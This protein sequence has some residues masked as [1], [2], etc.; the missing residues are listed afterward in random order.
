[1]MRSTTL[2]AAALFLAL[3]LGCHPMN[4]PDLEIRD[5]LSKAAQALEAGDSGAAVAILDEGYQGPEGMNKAATAF[6]LAQVLK[7]G[8]VGVH[9]TD[10]D[11]GLSGDSAFEKVHVLLTQSGANLLPDGAKKVYILHWVKRGSAWRVVDIQ[12]FTDRPEGN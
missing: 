1:M 11:I 9:I 10:Q 7:Q 5:T 4:R 12:D 6:F 3:G 8:K 2:P